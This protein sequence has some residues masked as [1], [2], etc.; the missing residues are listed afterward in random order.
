MVSLRIGYWVFN[1]DIVFLPLAGIF[2][3]LITVRKLFPGVVSSRGEAWRIVLWS[4]LGAALAARLYGLVQPWYFQEAVFRN[5]AWMALRFGSMGGILGPMAV[6][7]LYAAIRGHV[8]LIYL[9]AVVPGICVGGFVARLACLFQGCCQGVPYVS[10]MELGLRPGLWWPGLDLVSYAIAG[11]V[12]YSV[13][14]R[15]NYVP[16]G[17]IFALFCSV[18]GAERLI[19]E[20]FRNTYTLIGPLTGGQILSILL[21]IVGLLQCSALR[22]PEK[23]LSSETAKH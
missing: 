10:L 17:L 2:F 14:K 18:Y 12:T 11:L 5:G 8:P 7:L 19:I 3:A 20:G 21:L 6:V 13:P 16:A 15:M 23:A 1:P 9:D 4:C 22:W